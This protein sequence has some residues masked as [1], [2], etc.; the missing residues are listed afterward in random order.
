MGNIIIK[1]TIIYILWAHQGALMEDMQINE[2]TST[3]TIYISVPSHSYLKDSNNKE[4]SSDNL[5]HYVYQIAN[6][7]KQSL[8]IN[9]NV[10]V[11]FDV[12]IREDNWTEEDAKNAVFKLTQ[13]FFGNQELTV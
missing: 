2:E 10:D 13:H 3:A 5:K 4:L 7:L 6:I 11:T 9:S 1:D 8:K 12:V